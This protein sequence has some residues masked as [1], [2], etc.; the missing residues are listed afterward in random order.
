MHIIK[1][2]ITVFYYVVMTLVSP[3]ANQSDYQM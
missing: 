1:W 2:A 3:Q